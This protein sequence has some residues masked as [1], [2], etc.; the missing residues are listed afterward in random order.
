M[1]LQVFRGS[2]QC[3]SVSLNYSRV[4]LQGSRV[5]FQT[6]R[7]HNNFRLSLHDSRMSLHSPRWASTAPDELELQYLCQRRE[8]KSFQSKSLHAS[9]V[10]LKYLSVSLPSRARPNKEPLHVSRVSLDLSWAAQLLH[11]WYLSSMVLSAGQ[12][13]NLRPSEHVQ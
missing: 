2:L 10:T 1:S 9:R 12:R 11:C 8:P 7:Y 5:S 13:E 3:S 6:S 4:S